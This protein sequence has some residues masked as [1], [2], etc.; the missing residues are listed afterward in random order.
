MSFSTF[1]IDFK[2]K[3]GKDRILFIMVLV[4]KIGFGLFQELN[5]YLPIQQEP[6]SLVLPLIGWMILDQTII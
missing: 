1:S 2:L 4:P 6:V 5:K 3:E